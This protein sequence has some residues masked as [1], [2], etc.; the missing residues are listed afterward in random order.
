[1]KNFKLI[2][3][4]VVI[5]V[6]ALTCLVSLGGIAGLFPVDKEALG[7]LTVAVLIESAVC[8][9]LLFKSARFFAPEDSIDNLRYESER[10][11]ATLWHHEQQVKGFCVAVAPAATNF[12]TYLRAVAQLHTLELISVSLPYWTVALTPEGKHFCQKITEKLTGITDH[13]FTEASPIPTQPAPTNP[14]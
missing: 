6:Y 5:G 13:Y 9:L 4:W 7:R 12:R 8:V 2:T 11:L 10:L 14:Q 3:F 1:M